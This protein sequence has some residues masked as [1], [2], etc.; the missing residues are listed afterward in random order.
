[1]TQKG[2]QDESKT[3]AEQTKSMVNK[4]IAYSFKPRAFKLIVSNDNR[5]YVYT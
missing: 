4:N 2:I 3:S 1:M 5:I